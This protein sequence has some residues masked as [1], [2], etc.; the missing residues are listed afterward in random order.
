MACAKVTSTA[1]TR[2][3][4]KNIDGAGKRR[5][6]RRDEDRDLPVAD[7]FDDEGGYQGV[8]DLHERG[9]PGAPGGSADAALGEVSE[10]R[11]SGIRWNSPF[12]SRS[13]TPSANPT[14][15]R[16][17]D[18]KADEQTAETTEDARPDR[19]RQVRGDR[20]HDGQQRFGQLDQQQYREVD[21]NKDDRAAQQRPRN[22]V[23]GG[24]HAPADRS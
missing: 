14:A 21:R 4:G 22:E 3:L 15:H 9:L 1:C 13:Q 19:L 23:D 16:K 12:S 8:L 10:E 6:H 17:A 5:R 7:L 24:F 18:Q 2:S 20:E 11:V